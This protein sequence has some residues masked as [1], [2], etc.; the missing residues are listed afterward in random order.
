VLQVHVLA[1]VAITG[2]TV[3][4]DTIL[5]SGYGRLVDFDHDSARTGYSGPTS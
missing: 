1:R 5:G 3:A 2:A 4:D